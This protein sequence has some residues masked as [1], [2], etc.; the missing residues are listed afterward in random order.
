MTKQQLESI[1]DWFHASPGRIS[2]LKAVN[3]I[4]VGS[5]AAAFFCG[6]LVRPGFQDPK[7]TLRLVLTCGVPF[8]LLSAVRHVLDLPRPFE[9]YDLEPLLP[10]ETPGRGFPS[11]HVFSIFVIGTCFCYLEPWL[12]WTLLGLGAALGALR[13]LSAVHFERDVLVG[14]AIGILS[15]VIGFGLI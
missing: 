3:G 14:A 6:V 2:A 7:L 9:V 1:S 13:V 10:R 4:C 11:R 5:A 15:G 12:G 8:V